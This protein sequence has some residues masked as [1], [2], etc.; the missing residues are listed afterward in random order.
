MKLVIVT[1]Y[2]LKMMF[3]DRLFFAAMILIPLFITIA[4]GYALRNEK[5][6]TIPVAFVD[7]DQSEYSKLLISRLSSKEGFQIA[8]EDRINAVE[9]LKANKVEAVFIIKQGFEER[10]TRRENEDLMEML[11][12]PASF[13]AA[14][15]TE[16]VAG[17]VIRFTSGHMAADWVQKQYKKLKKPGG[18]K[19]TEEVL[20]E[21]DAQWTPKPLMTIQYVELDHG[22]EIEV[23]SVS[24]PAATATSTGI[25]VVFTM[26]YI[27]FSS[28]W[29]IE[30]KRN[31]TLKRLVSGPDALGYSFAGS[32]ISLAIS[33][34]FQITLFALVDKVAFGVD[35][36]PGARSYMV[37]GAYLFCVIA[38][39]MFLSSVLKT[40]AQLQA[41]APVFALLTG[42]VGG[43]FWNFIEVSKE[44]E[45]L[46]LLTPQGW[47]LRGINSLLAGTGDYSVA[48]G[49]VVVLL[50]TSLILLPLS[51]MIIKRTVEK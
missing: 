26:F 29:L 21:V 22:M 9:K 40:P 25:I 11:K 12:S 43:C 18:P 6:N 30:E 49:S 35:L 36:F 3:S 20:Q 47:A 34:A 7:E 31:G 13:S 32:I 1:Y 4:T 51:Y 38:L 10:I 37:F 5:L 50:I 28:G 17:E 42:F 33:G 2:K 15:I 46:S 41:G 27:L 48:V 23:K 24:L 19:L 8:V 45:Q 14:F 16:V 39:S 44:L